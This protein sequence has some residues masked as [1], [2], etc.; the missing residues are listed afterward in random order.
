LVVVV[1]DEI[2]TE[3]PLSPIVVVVPFLGLILF[4]LISLIAIEICN[5]Q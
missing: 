5:E 1:P 4:D 2:V 3:S